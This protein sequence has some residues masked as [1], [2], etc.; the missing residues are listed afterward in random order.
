[1][2]DMTPHVSIVLPV[3]NE[4]ASLPGDLESIQQAM[5]A[6]GYPYELLIIDDGSS[7]RSAEIAAAMGVKVIR[8]GTNRGYG[9]AIKTGIRQ[10]A[11]EIIVTTDADGTYPNREIPSLLKELGR[12]DLVVG[13]RRSEAGSARLLRRPAKWAIRKLACFLTQTE[14]PDLNSGMRAF[15]KEIALRH[16]NLLPTGFSCSTTLSM[17]FLCEGYEV[18]YLPIDYAP[19]I[20]RSKFHPIQDTINF[21]TL[22]WR[23]IFYFNPLRILGPLG[24]SLLGLSVGKAIYDVIAYRLHIATSTVLLF[25]LAVQSLVIGLIADLIIKRS[26]P[27]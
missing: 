3:Y 9:S 6:S 5:G 7:D 16:L 23:M 22:V 13:A 1:M 21:I 2:N 25:S 17:I 10:S 24:L 19:R 4:E 27:R 14:I 18:A 15:R 26:R 12:H 8:H 20:G 11:G